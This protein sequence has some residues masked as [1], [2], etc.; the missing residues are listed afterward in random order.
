MSAFL[1]GFKVNIAGASCK[2]LILW[3]FAVIVIF[4]LY[5]VVV[6]TSYN[7]ITIPT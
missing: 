3:D 6:D 4:N 7:I 1:C 5:N 2:V